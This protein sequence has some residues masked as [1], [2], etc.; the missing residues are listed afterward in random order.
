M[1]I[2]RGFLTPAFWSLLPNEEVAGSELGPQRAPQRR[3]E[4][5]LNES[6]DNF[7]RT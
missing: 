3:R 5:G 4:K 7:E 6:R 2:E 1:L